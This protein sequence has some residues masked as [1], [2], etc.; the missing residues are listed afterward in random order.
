MYINCVVTHWLNNL[1][2]DKPFQIW[3]KCYKSLWIHCWQNWRCEDWQLSVWFVEI[4][5]TNS[6]CNWHASVTLQFSR[7]QNHTA[8]ERC[9]L[10]N[11]TEFG[12]GVSGWGPL[13]IWMDSIMNRTYPI[14]HALVFSTENFSCFRGPS[15]RETFHSLGSVRALTGIP[16]MALTA[17]AP[18]AFTREIVHSLC[19]HEPVTTEWSLQTF[20]IVFTGDHPSV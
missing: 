6:L 3:H 17:S 8:M 5:K 13:Y 1:I 14:T 18:S 7:H 19:L 10:R 16:F 4:I 20:S 2:G 15:F 11:E 12:S 9:R